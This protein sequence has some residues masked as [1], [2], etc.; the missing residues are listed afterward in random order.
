M[1]SEKGENALRILTFSGKKEDWMIWSD[2]FMAKA[3]M[4]GYN[5]VLDGTIIVPEGK[6]INPTASQEEAMK[7]NKMAHNELILA[8]TDKITFGIVKNAK[9]EELKKGNAKLACDCLNTGTKL[10]VLNKEYMS[11]E[12]DEIKK[13]PEDFIMDLDEIRT[14]M[15]DD[16]FDEVITDKSF[17]LHV[18]NLLPKEYESII[19]TLERDL[20]AGLLTIENLKEQVHSKYRRLT[21]KMDIKD[22]ELALNATNKYNYKKKQRFKGKC[23]ICSKYGHKAADCWENKNNKNKKPN[24]VGGDKRDWHFKGK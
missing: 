9:T 15:T 3:M 14:R 12:L 5:E 23:R 19:K 7:M 1:S 17:M 11:M 13:D 21:K 10:L 22:N 24:Q 2:K 6:T 18:L 4:K 8:C 16:P 20:D